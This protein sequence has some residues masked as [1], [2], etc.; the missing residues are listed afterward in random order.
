MNKD[1][2]NL[3][4]A[5]KWRPKTFDEIIGQ[6]IAIKTLQ[7]GLFL[8]KFFPVYLFAGQRGCGKTSSARIFA[9]A[10]NCQNLKAF[11]KKSEEKVPCLK[12]DSCKSMLQGNHPDFIEIDAASHTGVD[13]VRQ[14]LESCAYMPLTGNKKIYLIDEA[15]MLSKAAF[16]A[17]LKV[18][19]EPPSTVLFMLATTEIHKIP[20]TVLSRCFQVI[21][22]PIN[23]IALKDHLAKLSESENIDIEQQAI[24]MIIEETEGS[25][26]DAIN[27]LERVRFSDE[28]ITEETILKVLGKISEKDFYSIF[29]SLI[30]QN[31]PQVLKLL[32]SI[33]FQTL[34]PQI[35]WNALIQACRNLMWVK[36]GTNIK[37]RNIETLKN[38]A[39]KTS[40]NRIQAIFQLLWNQEPIFLQTTQKH[41][42][43]ESA[44]I[45]IC[46]QTDI[47]DLKDLI[48]FCNKSD[49]NQSNNFSGN[50]LETNNSTLLT[51]TQT[52]NPTNV[53]PINNKPI[54]NNA[55]SIIIS[56]N[57]NEVENAD[58]S[59]WNKFVQKIIELSDP[60]L[61]SILKQAKFIKNDPE[62]K[63]VCISLSNN[64]SFFKDKIEESKNLW[65]KLLQLSFPEYLGFEFIDLPTKQTEEQ[66]TSKNDNP[67]ENTIQTTNNAPI[68]KA[69]FQSKPYTPQYGSQKNNIDI[70]DKEKWP[71]A[72]LIIKHFPGKIK[73]SK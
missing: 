8:K 55:E 2:S 5:R 48:T 36:Y 27:L 17:F 68:S 61:E 59:P 57:N 44:L 3:N 39:S 72:N 63:M 11:Q 30:K 20:Q 4:L 24:E 10:V 19:E 53:N 51:K 62:K 65:L 47:E 16:N 52:V 69:Q 6:N 28:K 67:T 56:N 14:I 9:A 42:F 21:F 58:I 46:E 7:N 70:S 49:Q 37:N 15:H 38:L 25:A 32:E 40:I 41:I 29:E 33:N 13:N 50:G 60:M 22:K 18:L 54:T 12:C 66:K 26:R 31:V 71:K 1:N 64:G 23:N 45:Q 34:N 73:L 35:F 43:L